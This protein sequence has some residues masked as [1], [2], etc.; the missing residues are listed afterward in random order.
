MKNPWAEY[1]DRFISKS[2]DE[3][4]VERFNKQLAAVHRSLLHVKSQA[5][6]DKQ[7]FYQLLNMSIQLQAAIALVTKLEDIRVELTKQ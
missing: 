6:Y 5:N 2:D 1:F 7:E 3:P 4:A